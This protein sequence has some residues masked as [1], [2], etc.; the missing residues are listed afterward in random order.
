MIYPIKKISEHSAVYRGFLLVHRPATTLNKIARYE[1]ILSEQSFGLFDAQA[2]A[3]NYIDKL[4]VRNLNTNFGS[5]E[6]TPSH[7]ITQAQFNEWARLENAL[8]LI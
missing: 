2:Q 1:V 5:I 4:Y 3:T 6:I 8:N 7:K